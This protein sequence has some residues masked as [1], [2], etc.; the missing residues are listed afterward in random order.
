MLAKIRSMQL[1]QEREGLQYRQ[2]RKQT[3]MAETTTSTSYSE[4]VHD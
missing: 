4:S 1:L 3:P 2:R